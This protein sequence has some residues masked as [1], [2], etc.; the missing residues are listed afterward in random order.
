MAISSTVI[1]HISS[2]YTEIMLGSNENYVKEMS[3][4]LK[5]SKTRR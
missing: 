3:K 5:P 2:E 1:I 4:N